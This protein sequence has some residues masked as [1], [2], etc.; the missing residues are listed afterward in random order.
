MFPSKISTTSVNF[1]NKLFW[2][3]ILSVSA[4]TIAAASE[5]N[6]LAIAKIQRDAGSEYAVQG[7][8]AKNPA[9]DWR[10]KFHND[11]VDIVQTKTVGEKPL[12]LRLSRIGNA[13][14]LHGLATVKPVITGNRASY[15]RKN[16]EEWYVNGPLGLEQG[17]NVTESMGK[18]LVLEIETSWLAESKDEN[19]QLVNGDNRW[20]FGALYAVDSAGQTLPSTMNVVNGRV[21]LKVETQNAQFPVMIDPILTR[22]ATLIANDQ[23][24]FLGFGRSVAISGDGNT[25]IVGSDGNA[26][27]IFKRTTTGWTQVQ[28]LVKPSAL[29]CNSNNPAWFGWSVALSKD[30]STAMVGASG[31][32]TLYIGG[33]IPVPVFHSCSDLPVY[34][35]QGA[36]WVLEKILTTS[37]VTV[38]DMFGSSISLSQDGSRAVVGAQLTKCTSRAD[39][40]GA[41]Y[42]FER[43]ASGW[44]SPKRFV[45]ATT[46][47][48]SK[49]YFGATT[50]ISADGLWAL[51]GAPGGDTA[52]A[53]QRQAAPAGW[54]QI[55]AIKF[56]VTRLT[57]DFGT[58]MALS[59]IGDSAVI[60]AESTTNIADCKGDYN[61]C[62]AVYSFIRQGTTW[63]LQSTFTASDSH[64]YNYFGE[65]LAMSA[66]GKRVVVGTGEA[67][68][69]NGNCGAT[70][71][72]DRVGT[73]WVQQGRVTGPSAGLGGTDLGGD[74]GGAVSIG[75]GGLNMLVAA[76]RDNCAVGKE[77]GKVYHY[78]IG[79]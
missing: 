75:Q 74:F 60:S 20:Y 16:V 65:S 2:H 73:T 43:G 71:L 63:T 13:R 37:S 68:C 3:L 78:D 21:R 28:K 39:I 33:F 57:K 19:I 48:V 22:K 25:A 79:N 11:G 42:F 58:A 34:R 18:E 38:E 23:T 5:L 53:F 49:G 4:S 72:F 64:S 8:Q 55:Q 66:N 44:T 26:A 14:K 77:C 36:Q 12:K 69:V 76:R 32:F 54:K 9:L 6:P 56:P 46:Y 29:R 62:G 52:W 15:Q 47:D 27:Y 40:C 45:N 50:A 59:A 41:A 67:D 7:I 51:V 31:I 24:K 30:G 1:F 61:D 10:L 70:Y 35:K 17:F